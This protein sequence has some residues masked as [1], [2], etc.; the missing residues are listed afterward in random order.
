MS[1]LKLSSKTE[2]APASSASRNCARV[3]TSICTGTPASR[4]RAFSRAWLTPPAAAIW[5]SLIRMPSYRARRWFL[6]PPTRTAYFCA[7]RRPGKVLRV[8]RMDALVPAITSTYWRVAVATADS[9]CRKLRA[10]RSAVSKARAGASI[11]Q[12]TLSAVIMSP[13]A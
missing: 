1:L 5:F 10:L 6:P 8:S 3:S 13:S 7:R 12:T 11:V 2:T 4:L 9:S